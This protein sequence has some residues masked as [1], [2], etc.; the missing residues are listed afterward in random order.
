MGDSKSKDKNFTAFDKAES[1][2]NSKM[3]PRRRL[4]PVEM[5]VRRKQTLCFNCDE[6]YHIR[7]KSKTNLLS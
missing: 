3:T 5:D 4:T 1:S 2:F 6:V 7:H